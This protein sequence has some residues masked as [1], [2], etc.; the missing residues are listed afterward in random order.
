MASSAPTPPVIRFG[1]FEL[2]AARSELR[3]SDISLK[4]HPQP[5]RV[6]M[7]LA[8]RPGQI[9]SREEIQRCLWG[10]NTFVDYERG[11][12][13]C[14]NQI[15]GALGDDAESPRYVET[16]PRRG[17]RF[18][19]SVTLAAAAKHPTPITHVSVRDDPSEVVAGNGA[20]L[21]ST[22]DIHVVPSIVPTIPLASSTRRTATVAL[23][24]LSVIAILAAGTF[25]YFHR[26]PKLTDR[27]SIVLADFMNT[28]GD[29]VFDATLRQGLSVQLEQ[30]PFLS[31]I[32][33]QQIQ[34]TLQMMGQK[35]D[36]KLTPE[37]A[38]ELCQRT[39]SAA[40]LNSV[41]A[42]IG[43]QYTLILKAV[44][45]SNGESLAS[46]E[47]KANDKNH[48]LDALGK[49]ARDVRSKL[50]ESLNTVQK[51]D[52]PLEQ[53]TTPSLE[54]LQAYSLGRNAMA[55]K[56]ESATAVPLFRRAIELDPNFA[57]AYASLGMSYSNL[58]QS[59]LATENARTAYELRGPISQQEKFYIESHY[60]HVALRD[61]EKARQVYELWQETYPRAALPRGNLGS[62]YAEMGQYEKAIAEEREAIRLNPEG[63]AD[64]AGVVDHYVCL[65]RL[66]EARSV[67]EEAKAKN[68]DSSRLRVGLYRLAFL[69]NDALGMQEQVA[70]ARGKPGVEDILLATEAD[71]AAYF[72]QLRSA[73]E[74][75]R[76]AVDSAE[77]AE[78]KETAASYSAL[79]ALHEALLGNEGEAR[80]LAA[81]AMRRSAGHDV[82][83]R[84]ALALAYAKDGGLTQALTNDLS[85]CC[86]QDALVQFSYLPTLR[87]Q[88]ALNHEDTSKAIETLEAAV[89]YEL[90]RY[91]GLYPVYVR[92]EAYLAGHQGSE[93]SVEFQKILDHRGIVVNSPIGALAHLQLAR[94]YI[95]QG[96]NV[97]ARA[98]YQDFLTLWKDAD[99]DIPI[100]IA[101]KSEYA[102]LN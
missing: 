44:N 100:L 6:L 81:S 49:A 30:S 66:N 38:R 16:L 7:L 50:G 22:H 60:Q 28:T 40:V 93:A 98:A 96:D 62:V 78:E 57:M 89:P 27:D 74:F 26:P 67:A 97:K 14:I 69:Q 17:Y 46:T 61:L 35:P 41:I 56:G 45:C 43:T 9:V 75:S 31:I 54:A 34:Q 3:K 24:A 59:V 55:G 48:V 51:F 99:P 70:W 18:I 68:L 84:A 73:R 47:A 32:S 8:E 80:R 20:G 76:R 82:E 5:F 19:A 95:L 87:A 85:R 58:G 11:I 83:Y 94:A 52:T 101:A 23:L 36:T 39:G 12:N 13:F 10:D 86:A 91:G 37:I 33:D 102:K 92:G 72:G 63:A 65:N 15:R 77:Q 1:A 25:F 4:I 2:D 79:S 21:A 29:A 90:A 53:A 42:Q 71:T 88:I 64:Y